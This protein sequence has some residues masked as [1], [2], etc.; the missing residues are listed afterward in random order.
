M[1]ATKK[2]GMLFAC[3]FLLFAACT[4]DTALT[5]AQLTGAKLQ[6]LMKSSSFTSFYIYNFGSGNIEFTGTNATIS[7]DGFLTITST[8]SG[9]IPAAFSLEDLK[10]YQV[11]TNTL[12]LYF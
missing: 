6:A 11:V 1:N 7:G 12:D 2:I 9:S 4:K 8:A 5:Q 10:A 3:S